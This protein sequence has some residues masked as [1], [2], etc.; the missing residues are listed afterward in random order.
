MPLKTEPLD[1]PTM[2][3][4][5][6]LDVV[7][8]LIIFFMVSTKFSEEERQ[9]TVQVPTVSDSVA[10]SSQPDE[11]IVNVTVDGQISVRTKPY[12][13]ESLKEMLIGVREGFP[14]QAVVIRG[15]GRGTY[16]TVVDVMSAVK[17]AGIKTVS[18]AHSPI[19]K[20]N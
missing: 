5:S 17:S 9:S 19:P 4:T 10:M 1:E 15:D 8:L 7:M 6:M 12:T 2:N 16:Q 18:L 20:G 3:L 14:G 13:L 11:L